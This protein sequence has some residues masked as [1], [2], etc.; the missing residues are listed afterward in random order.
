MTIP[1]VPEAL[2][3]KL[4]SGNRFLL[5]SHQRPDGDAIGSEIGLARLL[6]QLG[7][8][9]TIWNHDATPAIYLP[10][11]GT[12][13]IHV[14][15]EPPRGFPELFGAV[16]ALECPTLDRTGLENHLEGLP[17]LNIDHHLGN[18]HYGT[19][20]W[21]DSGA[22]A[23]GEMVYRIAR[24]LKIQI[25]AD[26]ANALY[27]TLVSDTGGFRFSNTTSE[28]FNAAAELV[29]SGASPETVAKWLFE[30]R[31]ETTLRLLGEMLGTLELHDGKRL[32]TTWLTRGM[33]ER[34]GASDGDSEGLIDYSRSIA[35]VE[36]VALFRQ[37]DTGGHKV[38]LR[39]RGAVNVEKIARRFGGGGHHNAAGFQTDLDKEELLRETVGALSAALEP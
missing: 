28:A 3:A 13:R 9:A 1:Q 34:A 33:F 18:E 11:P 6:R 29:S 14:G 24:A 30:S 16:I 2:I 32:A 10:L 20:N 7:K 27:M 19:V 39:S 15:P 17:V 21:V 23:V 25:D 31:P 22:P 4:R 35:G 38:S 8:G 26:T 5:S 12:E 37:L 36:A